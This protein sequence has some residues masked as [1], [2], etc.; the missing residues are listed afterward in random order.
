L[1]LEDGT[2][3]QL[4]KLLLCI[5]K[6]ASISNSNS[7]LKAAVKGY[8]LGEPMYSAVRAIAEDTNDGSCGS[9]V[10]AISASLAG[11]VCAVAETS[12]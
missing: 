10:S 3:Q 1:Q 5:A 11:K 4:L 9:T 12:L 6:A 8:L 7:K 2:R